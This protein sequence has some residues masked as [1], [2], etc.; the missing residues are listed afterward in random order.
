MRLWRARSSAGSRSRSY[1]Q[2]SSCPLPICWYTGKP[3]SSLGPMLR[4]RPQDEDEPETPYN[5]EGLSSFALHGADVA[6]GS[7][8]GAGWE[9]IGLDANP[10]IG[11]PASTYGGSNRK[12][13]CHRRLGGDSGPRE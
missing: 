11:P 12:N 2:F 4:R 8:P 13:K 6:F 3:I 7:I 9:R 1:S 5:P 10:A